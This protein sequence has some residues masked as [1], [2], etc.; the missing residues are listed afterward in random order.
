[1]PVIINN[2]FNLVPNADKMPTEVYTMHAA[3]VLILSKRLSLHNAWFTLQVI[4]RAG[5]DFNLLEVF[6]MYRFKSMIYC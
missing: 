4:T 5:P 6:L 1:M 3:T 2:L